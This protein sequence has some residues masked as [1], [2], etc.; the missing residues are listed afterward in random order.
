MNSIDE[1]TDTHTGGNRIDDD[2][3]KTITNHQ[4][5]DN[6]LQHFFTYQETDRVKIFDIYIERI[7]LNRGVRTEFSHIFCRYLSE[8]ITGSNYDFGAC[9]GCVDKFGFFEKRKYRK[10][11]DSFPSDT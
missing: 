3:G 4:L 7:K 1:T 9:T 8:I 6:I 5:K 10:I 2:F 11:L